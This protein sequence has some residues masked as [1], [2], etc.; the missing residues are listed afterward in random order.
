MLAAE[1]VCAYVLR[2]YP[3]YG[4]VQ[5]I[6]FAGAMLAF[7]PIPEN[8]F[9]R[10]SSF[11]SLA[12][13]KPLS[14]YGINRTRALVSG[15]LYEISGTFREIADLFNTI[16]E[17]ENP[18]L[19]EDAI[20]AGVRDLCA[21]CSYSAKCRASSFPKKEEVKRLISIARG[22]GRIS[23]VDLPKSFAQ[24]C[25]QNGKVIYVINKYVGEYGAEADKRKVI[26]ETRAVVS[27]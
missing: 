6:W 4:Y 19:Y 25:S 9:E 2:L 26:N 1:L 15:R 17:A 20:M 21:D 5:I 14:R 18:F 23:A 7:A 22:K 11:L 8:L 10:A 13:D 24:K 12:S 16:S 27:L 3:D